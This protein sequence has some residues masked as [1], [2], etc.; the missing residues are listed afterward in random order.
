MF[1]RTEVIKVRPSN[2]NL[3]NL[4]Y[5]TPSITMSGEGW[6]LEIELNDQQL[7]EISTRVADAIKTRA[8]NSIKESK[9]LL[10]VNEDDE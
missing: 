2:V 4:S 6:S 1:N 10:G 7:K 9:E 3:W 5:G 8:K